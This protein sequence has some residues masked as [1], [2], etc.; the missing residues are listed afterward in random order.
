MMGEMDPSIIALI[1][2]AVLAG[3]VFYLLSKL[4]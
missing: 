3:I 1:V 4:I 2:N